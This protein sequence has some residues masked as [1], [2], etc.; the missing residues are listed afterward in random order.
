MTPPPASSTTLIAA[1]K[2]RLAIVA[3]REFYQRDPAGHLARLQSVSN[4]I[5]SAAAQLSGEVDPQ[6]AHFLQRCSYDKAL[7]FLE[8]QA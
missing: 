2:D 7:A 8:G 6:L 1:L 3:D 4:E 5:A